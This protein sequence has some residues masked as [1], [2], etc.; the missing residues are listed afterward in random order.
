MAFILRPFLKIGADAREIDYCRAAV[1]PALIEMLDTSPVP[2]PSQIWIF[3]NKPDTLAAPDA[4]N[5]IVQSH[6]DIFIKG[7]LQLQTRVA[8]ESIDF[9]EEC[10]RTFGGWSKLGSTTAPCHVDPTFTNLEL[11]RSTK[12]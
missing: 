8:D 7:C 11:G 9:V 6:V 2:S 3:V 1:P 5:P 10:V 12:T 4:Q